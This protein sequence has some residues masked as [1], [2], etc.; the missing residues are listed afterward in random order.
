MS[1]GFASKVEGR[2]L[3][4]HGPEERELEPVLEP[5][6]L[7]AEHTSRFASRGLGCVD[8]GVA[9]GAP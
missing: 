6:L 5:V 2:L 9:L 1:I 4:G 7:L 8:E 3:A